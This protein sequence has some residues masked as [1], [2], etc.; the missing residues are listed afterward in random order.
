[1]SDPE[2]TNGTKAR[3]DALERELAVQ[4]ERAD[5]ESE[6][7]DTKNGDL[8]ERINS[9]QKTNYTALSLAIGVLGGVFTGALN[10]IGSDIESNT[11][12]LDMNAATLNQRSQIIGEFQ[13][14]QDNHSQ[15]LLN[16]ENHLD[17]LLREIADLQAR[18]EHAEDDLSL[19]ER[20]VQAEESRNGVI[21]SQV[22][23]NTGVIRALERQ[24]ED[25]DKE[26]TRALLKSQ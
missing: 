26:G 23:S 24:V 11:N 21:E 25:I 4:R 5:K 8:H 12:R 16:H 20:R 1:M 10:F 14:K 19:N 7:Q 3:L 22:N 18:M 2:P 9:G 13:T 6:R 17:D 15:W